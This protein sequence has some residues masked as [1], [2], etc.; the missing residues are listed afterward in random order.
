M[1]T[2]LLGYQAHPASGRASTARTLHSPSA[3]AASALH[4]TAASRH[5]ACMAHG[6]AFS[7]SA[8]A[9][10]ARSDSRAHA[11]SRSS[12]SFFLVLF[13]PLL[14]PNRDLACCCCVRTSLPDIG[15][16]RS[17]QLWTRRPGGLMCDCCAL[18]SQGCVAGVVVLCDDR[19]C[20]KC[21][22]SAGA[23]A[24]GVAA[25]LALAAEFPPAQRL[26]ALFL[27]AADSHR[28]NRQ[29]LRR[30]ALMPRAAPLC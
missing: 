15:W 2:F 28:L 7:A 12:P 3:S 4:E 14:Y 24:E 29:L 13:L 23:A 11:A 27:E 30:V 5:S 9:A 26:Y 22:A 6:T 16:P 18:E 1:I 21:R 10:S 8:V 17:L 20:R 25:A 19:V